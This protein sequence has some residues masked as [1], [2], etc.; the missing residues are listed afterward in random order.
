MTAS[1]T[2]GCAICTEGFDIH[3]KVCATRCGHVYHDTCLH[4]WMMSQSTRGYHPTTC[5]KCRA[6]V[7]NHQVLRLFLHQVDVSS[8]RGSGSEHDSHSENEAESDD[9]SIHSYAGPEFEFSDDDTWS[10]DSMTEEEEER[11]VNDIT[12]PFM[13]EV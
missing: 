12:S 10:A 11:T 2:F 1:F 8:E 4:R 9:D 7:S 3:K 13:D 6:S 5:P